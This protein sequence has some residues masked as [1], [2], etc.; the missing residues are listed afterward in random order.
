MEDRKQ[1]DDVEVRFVNKKVGRGLFACR[2]FAAG[3]VVLCEWPLASMQ[4]SENRAKLPSCAQCHCSLLSPRQ[5]IEA[6]L[7]SSFL[8]LH[9]SS[10]DAEALFPRD[11]FP[12]RE[13]FSC[14]QGCGVLY[15]SEGCRAFALMNHHHLLC[16]GR[17]QS[18]D[19]P[20]VRFKEHALLQND[21][22][23]LA[24]EILA[25]VLV[26]S[27]MKAEILKELVGQLKGNYR[28]YRRWCDAKLPGP[29]EN[30]EKFNA[31]VSSV[32]SESYELFKAALS[33]V[34]SGD[35]VW[36]LITEELYSGILSMFE[37]NNISIEFPS[38]YEE[39]VQEMVSSDE[40]RLGA[41]QLQI[42]KKLKQVSERE[43]Q[44]DHDD[45]E[46]GECDAEMHTHDGEE[47]EQEE[48]EEGE[49]EVGELWGKFDGVGLYEVASMINHSCD[50]NVDF[51]YLEKNG[52][53]HVIARRP[54]A[55][56]EEILHA[57]I[58]EMWPVVERNLELVGYGFV[59]ECEKCRSEVDLNVLK[60]VI[61][62]EYPHL[63]T[64]VLFGP[65]MS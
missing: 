30:V 62:E 58:S 23:L 9:D 37:L 32:L 47:E 8:S 28:H 14:L 16:V 27:E 10:E 60:K 36:E 50:P 41:A 48:E 22:F 63:S 51:D 15:C 39:L 40:R 61:L 5:F 53:L 3:E 19:H 1:H 42:E 26:K 31:N 43:E 29:G 11:M 44:E 24:A 35:F 38:G 12:D 17:V 45:H 59:C 65:D 18:E 57:Y 52:K 7:S 21:Q 20:L 46:E 34:V 64:S 6:R 49:D 4:H 56:G 54:I 33:D 55:E 25:R 2:S 13:T